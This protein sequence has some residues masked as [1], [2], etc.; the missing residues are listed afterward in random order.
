MPRL[1]V[2]SKRA[3]KSPTHV[4]VAEEEEE[5]VEDDSPEPLIGTASQDVGNSEVGVLLV[6]ICSLLTQTLI[7][8]SEADE[9]EFRIV[10]NRLVAF[11]NL[12]EQLKAVLPR[13]RRQV[14]FRLQTPKRR[15]SAKQQ[16]SRRR[17]KAH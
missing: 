9:E 10:R 2:L 16:A 5:W 17:S 13:P 12:S 4:Q 1:R 14:G 15:V 8:L 6:Q 7:L 11:F 3:A